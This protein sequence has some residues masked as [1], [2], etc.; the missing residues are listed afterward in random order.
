M[1]SANIETNKV[2]VKGPKRL[3]PQF[4]NKINVLQHAGSIDLVPN[5]AID[6]YSCTRTNASNPK[7]NLLSWQNRVDT[8]S[9]ILYDVS[10]IITIIKDID[11]MQESVDLTNASTSSITG[12]G[13][14]LSLFINGVEFN[15]SNK[16]V[17]LNLGIE[18]MV[19]MSV[20]DNTVRSTEGATV[21][22]SF[23]QYEF[24]TVTL[25]MTGKA[26]PLYARTMET[27][28]DILPV[29][30]ISSESEV[31]QVAH[32]KLNDY[33]HTFADKV[34]DALNGFKQQ[35]FIHF[36]LL[37][38][39]MVPT[40]CHD[41]YVVLSDTIKQVLAQ[42]IATK[43]D[44]KN[45]IAIKLNLLVKEDTGASCIINSGLTGFHIISADFEVDTKKK[46]LDVLK[47][48][49]LFTTVSDPMIYTATSS[50]TYNYDTNKWARLFT[51]A[52]PGSVTKRK[53]KSKE[54]DAVLTTICSMESSGYIADVIN[55]DNFQDLNSE[56]TGT[57]SLIERHVKRACVDIVTNMLAGDT[58]HGYCKPRH[59]KEE[60]K[61]KA[62]KKERKI[63]IDARK[64]SKKA[65]KAAKAE[66]KTAKRIEKR[67]K[68]HQ[69]KALSASN[70]INL[71]S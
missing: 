4:A 38:E 13:I 22:N 32:D 3:K 37:Q 11:D 29:S 41:K 52:I 71:V 63:Q 26:K 24:M 31:F 35:S 21:D 49:I 65:K 9:P 2:N 50:M 12:H 44:K 14:D 67:T 7:G 10:N 59:D 64:A 27:P 58:E 25:P 48:I 70:D 18:M 56:S 30:G 46:D 16:S 33:L 66:K 55:R 61:S 57:L 15:S 1:S 5:D 36:Q 23:F 40:G 54:K 43:V 39:C 8:D 68:K 42:H 20:N 51:L 19:Q 53:K 6:G 47:S 17:K 62:K 34:F 28:H 60:L 69:N 45:D